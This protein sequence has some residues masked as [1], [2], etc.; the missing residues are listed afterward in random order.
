MRQFCGGTQ[1]CFGLGCLKNID[2]GRVLVVSDP[3]FYENGTAAKIAG[4][5]E[6]VRYFYKVSPDPSVALAAEGAAAVKEFVP[7]TILALGGGS[8][9]DCAK[10]MAYF[11]GTSAKLIAIPTTSGSGSEVTDFAILTHDGVKHPLVDPK[12]RPAMAIL[13]GSLVAKLP[14]NLIADGGFD[15][16][17]HALEAYVAKNATPYSDALAAGAF[18]DTLNGLLASY[19]GDLEAR[20]RVHYAATGAGLA[21]T[22]AGLGLCHALA[23]SLGG[24][25]HIPH[26]RLNAILLP[27]VLN[28]S[29]S[30]RYGELARLAGLEGKAQTVA[31]RNLRNA[32]LRLRRELELPSTLA[33][34][35]VSPSD[36]RKNSE[37]ILKAA[38]SD[39]CCDTNPTPV[40]MEMARAVLSEVTGHG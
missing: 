17:T 20:T 13:D 2:P 39:P 26:G 37:S 31:Q 15:V 8:A 29:P 19:R 7:D 22:N 23:H 6:A 4:G 38:L 35:G 30:P 16:L 24:A 40:T 32:L 1:I 12:L 9:M 18:R 11:S 27:A 33:E 25:F 21:F 10:A 5:A 36:V 34:A 28:H 14:K 3:Y